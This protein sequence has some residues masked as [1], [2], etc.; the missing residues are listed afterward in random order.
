MW[1]NTIGISY[2]CTRRRFVNTD[3][4]S[5]LSTAFNDGIVV[6]AAAAA[7]AT[8]AVFVVNIIA[9]MLRI[10]FSS[11]HTSYIACIDEYA[12]RIESQSIIMH[13]RQVSPEK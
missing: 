7:G 1:F 5:V 10:C 12:A 11:L 8:P 2:R 4:K 6:V 13:I 3:T 9:V